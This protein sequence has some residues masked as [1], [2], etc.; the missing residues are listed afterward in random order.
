MNSIVPGF[1]L[2]PFDFEEKWSA[3][4][5]EFHLEDNGWLTYMFNKR[6]RWIP[7]YYRDIPLGC[8]LEN[9]P[10]LKS[11]NSFFK[12][13]ENPRDTLVEFWLRFQCYGSKRYTQKSLDR[14]SDLSLPVTKTMLHLEIHASTVY[15]HALFYE[16]Q[17]QC[18]SSLNS[19]SAGDSSRDSTTRFLDVEDAI[20]RK[21]VRKIP[22][23]YLLSRWTK[24][25]KKMP[26]YDV[27]EQ[28]IGDDFDSSDVSK[29]QIS[30]VWSEFYSTLS[31]IKSLPEN[32][33]TELTDLLK[34]FTRKFKPYQTMTKQQELKM[35]LGVKCSDEIQIL[36]PVKS[37][38]KGSG[39]RLTSKKQMSIEKAQKPKR[40]CNNCKQMAH[41]D[42]RNCPNP[43]AETSEHSGDDNES[44]TSSVADVD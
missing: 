21:R 33:V 10:T 1:D 38:N 15:T 25:T 22:E 23:Q 24:N 26:L 31:L 12:L 4:I 19:C 11:M 14:D 28:L 34:A 29:L 27:H 5:K 18:V 30:N 17:K 42:K 41:H 9:N 37:K 3:L 44:D 7:A 43:A 35:L 20:L 13:F 6:Q 16:F 8:L 32:H 36:P 39:K 40:F 2:E